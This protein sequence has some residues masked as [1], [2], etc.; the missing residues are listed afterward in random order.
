MINEVED[1]NII[2]IEQDDT[3]LLL[4]NFKCKMK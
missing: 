2:N 4:F 3:F 1:I